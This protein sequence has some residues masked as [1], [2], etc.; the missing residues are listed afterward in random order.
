MSFVA[1]AF[2]VTDG[3]VA[4][5]KNES[6]R[7]AKKFVKDVRE[8]FEVTLIREGTY[9]FI[10]P[11]DANRNVFVEA[12]KVGAKVVPFTETKL[13][14]VKEG[15]W[16][17]LGQEA[18][19]V[20]FEMK[21]TKAVNP[22]EGRVL[23][24]KYFV[25]GIKEANGGMYATLGRV[26]KLVEIGTGLGKFTY[27]VDIENLRESLAVAEV[28]AESTKAKTKK[29]AIVESKDEYVDETDAILEMLLEND[30]GVLA[31]QA[32]NERREDVKRKIV[33]TD[34]SGVETEQDIFES[35]L[36]DSTLP[37]IS[38]MLTESDDD[39]EAEEV[40]GEVTEDKAT[41]E[42]SWDENSLL[43]SLLSSESDE[44]AEQV[45]E[46]A[47]EPA[48]EQ[49]A[50]PVVEDEADTAEAAEVVEE[51]AKEEDESAVEES[52]DLDP[53]QYLAMQDMVAL[54]EEAGYDLDKMTEDEIAAVIDSMTEEDG[55]NSDVQGSDAGDNAAEDIAETGD[56]EAE[57][58]DSFQV[59]GKA[60]KGEESK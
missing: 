17:E 28:K 58:D 25:L 13:S 15:Q 46:V 54:M 6:L 37:K 40:D 4:G 22:V 41:N 43:E 36:A 5:R 18:L 9:G 21:G 26:D 33:E 44:D 45:T 29:P 34:T 8:N 14:P 30:P 19:G 11:N 42:P 12:G 51:P 31:E 35:L 32:K 39:T 57:E 52:D 59:G 60:E 20:R 47:D 49:D 27:N 10:V 56:E 23:P 3:P 1:L 7:R 38:D 48:A 55:E 50:D 16:V 24:G 2:P 53:E